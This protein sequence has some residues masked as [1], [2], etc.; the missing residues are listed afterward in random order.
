MGVP[1]AT[2]LRDELREFVQT[3]RRQYLILVQEIEIGEKERQPLLSAGSKS[4]ANPQ[5]QTVGCDVVG[6]VCEGAA[7]AGVTKRTA[8]LNVFPAVYALTMF[9]ISEARMSTPS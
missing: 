7:A 5:W 9:P 1:L 8:A 2:R 4:D 6:I 3:L